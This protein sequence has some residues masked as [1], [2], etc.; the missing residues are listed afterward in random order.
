MSKFKVYNK[1]QIF[2]LPPSIN[3]FLPTNHLATVIDE[4]VEQ[5][6]T[7]RIEGRYSEKG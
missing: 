3:E 4:I 6:D 7:C 2:L 1:D 5:L